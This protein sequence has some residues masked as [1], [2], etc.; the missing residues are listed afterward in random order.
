LKIATERLKGSWWVRP[1]APGGDLAASRWRAISAI[2]ALGQAAARSAPSFSSLAEV[3]RWYAAEGWR[4]DAAYRQSE[5]IRVTAGVALEELDELFHRARVSYENWLD[6]LL[7][8]TATVLADVDVPVI[9]LQRSIH[10]RYVQ[11]GSERRAYVLVDALRYELGRDLAERLASVNA[12]ISV[13]AALATPPSITAVGMA[14]LLPGAD[15]SFRIAL[16]EKERLAVSVGGDAVKGVS[17]RVRRLENTHGKVVD[18]DLDR[19]AQFSN[20]E[21]RNKIGDASLVLV[22][23]S[24]IDAD[25]ESD[26][27]AASWGSFDMTLNVLHTAVAKLLHAGIRRVII[28]SDHG[29]LAM[30]QV[31]EERR[32]DKPATGTGEL[33][34]RAW[35]GRGGTVSESTFKIPLSAFGIASDLDIITPRGLGV[36]VSGGG[37][38]FFHGGLSPQEL[39]IP[40][41]TAVAEDISPE[42]QYRIHLGIAGERIT[43]GVVAVTVTMTGDLFTRQ[44][45]VRLQLVRNAQRVAVVVGGDGFDQA[46]ETIDATVDTPRVITMQVTANLLAG[47]TATLEVLD[48]GTGVRLADLEVE[49]ASTVFV[50]DDLG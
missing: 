14:A 12:E 36:F 15:T 8:S 43:T 32:I 38:Q 6:S 37:L 50:D 30:R 23:S 4:V 17:E 34:R 42:P 21:L 20:K 35:I 24:E 10:E 11:N 46:T 39:I 7:R 41:I 29:F 3:M 48:A 22:R 45:R 33:H 26:Q 13:S 49:V 18:L 9:D 16:G 25:G 44:S 27:L 1:E 31:G 19:V 40:V 5:F 2:A 47:S 28:T